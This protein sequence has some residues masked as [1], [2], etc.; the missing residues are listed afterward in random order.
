LG[1]LAFA[2]TC[3][4]AVPASADDDDL[5]VLLGTDAGAAI[6]VSA[7]PRCPEPPTRM[8]V[9][10]VRWEIDATKSAD[11]GATA[12][13]L[14]STEFRVD[15]SKLPGFEPGSFDRYSPVPTHRKEADEKSAA[16]A[17]Q[18]SVVAPNLRPGVYYAARVLAATPGGWIASET[19]RF[20]TPICPV[21]SADEG[22]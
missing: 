8:P 9:V 22:R 7:E 21:D 3:I 14:Q 15:V 20:L 13:L 19:V 18:L 17:L 4:F 5:P 10:K 11:A 1:C 12:D 16:T 2:W 6:Q